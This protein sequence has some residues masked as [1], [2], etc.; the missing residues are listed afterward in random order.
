MTIEPAYHLLYNPLDGQLS[1]AIKRAQG[2]QFSNF[3]VDDLKI[4]DELEMM[5][6]TGRFNTPLDA[7]SEK[8]YVAFVGGSG[9]TPVI[10]IIETTMRVEP[11]IQFILFYANQK[12]AQSFSVKN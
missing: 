12:R 4:G 1:V 11:K 6:P 2:G 3:A 9:V 5:H 10:S 7:D 8:F